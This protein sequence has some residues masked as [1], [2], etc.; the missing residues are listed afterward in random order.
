[1]IWFYV[2]YVMQEATG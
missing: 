1:M 2:I